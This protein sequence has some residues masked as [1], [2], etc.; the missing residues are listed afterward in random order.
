M[1]RS[2]QH[3]HCAYF[4]LAVQGLR[5]TR[6][7]RLEA[8]ICARVLTAGLRKVEYWGGSQERDCAGEFESSTDA[9]DQLLLAPH[10]NAPTCF[11]TARAI[12]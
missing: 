3:A 1:T 11:S 2:C 6:R 10:G 4:L 5:L 8:T 12:S 9:V 7:I